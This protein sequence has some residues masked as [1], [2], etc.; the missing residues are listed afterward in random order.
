[1]GGKCPHRK[2]KKRRL[3][4]KTDRRSKF[5]VKDILFFYFLKFSLTLF[6]FVSREKKKFSIFVYM[7]FSLTNWFLFTWRC[8][9]RWASETRWWAETLASRRGFARHGPVLLHP[10]RV[11]IFNCFC[12]FNFCM[13]DFVYFNVIFLVG[14]YEIKILSKF[15]F[16][17]IW[18]QPVLSE[19]VGTR[20]AF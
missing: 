4:H 5:L 13:L 12:N 9:L 2:V 17:V 6:L 3:S 11:N 1:M 19:C 7:F 16:I 15:V 20:R 10:L 8:C 14:W 18:I